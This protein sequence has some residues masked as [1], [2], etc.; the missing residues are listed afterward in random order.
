MGDPLQEHHLIERPSLFD[1]F[2]CRA[3]SDEMY[4]HP[5]FER[6]NAWI[7]HTWTPDEVV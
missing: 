3:I 4:N 5:L 7:I 1:P 2:S 6:Y